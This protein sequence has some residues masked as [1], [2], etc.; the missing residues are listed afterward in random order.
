MNIPP[1]RGSLGVC[2][3]FPLGCCD[4]NKVTVDLP[5]SIIIV[6]LTWECVLKVPNIDWLHSFKT[7]EPL[8]WK[9]LVHPARKKPYYVS[10]FRLCCCDHVRLCATAISAA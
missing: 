8:Q 3:I 10:G 6:F 4:N 5:Q 9:A 2:S 1:I 7:I